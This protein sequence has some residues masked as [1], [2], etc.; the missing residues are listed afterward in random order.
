MQL[1]E[2]LPH[3]RRH[4][5]ILAAMIGNYLST[6]EAHG[7]ELSP[8]SES[9]LATVGVLERPTMLVFKLRRL[10]AHLRNALVYLRGHRRH[11]LDS[12]R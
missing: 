8:V 2:E 11:H 10:P 9:V 5:V 7:L 4:V 6:P 3:N 12:F 1:A